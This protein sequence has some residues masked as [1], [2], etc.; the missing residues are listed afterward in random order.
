MSENNRSFASLP[1]SLQ[2]MLLDISDDDNRMWYRKVATLYNNISEYDRDENYIAMYMNLK[3]FLMKHSL[4]EYG[5]NVL[6]IMFEHHIFSAVKSQH[7]RSLFT[8]TNPNQTLFEAIYP[9]SQPY[10]DRTIPLSVMMGI[11]GK[12]GIQYFVDDYYTDPYHMPAIISYSDTI[13][14]EW[15][16]NVPIFDC[17]PVPFSINTCPSGTCVQVVLHNATINTLFA[18]I[19]KVKSIEKIKSRRVFLSVKKD[20]SIDVGFSYVD[21]HRPSSTFS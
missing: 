6:S 12:V 7:V 13:V 18:E 10:C 21:G 8:Y 2:A 19:V 20:G 17:S 16:G 4:D 1:V 3:S 5:V 14:S 9:E 11:D 15:L